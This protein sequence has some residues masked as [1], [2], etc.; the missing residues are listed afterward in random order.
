MNKRLYFPLHLHTTFSIGDGVPTPSEYATALKEK[1]FIGGGIADHGTLSGVWKFQKALKENGLK[2]ILGIEIYVVD[3][4]EKTRDS[5]HLTIFFK[6]KKGWESYLK[7]HKKAFF[8]GF[9]YKPR[10]LLDD[11]LNQPDLDI[12]V[13]SGCVYNLFLE[14][15]QYIEKFIEKFG[16]DFY[17]ELA[18][19]PSDMRRD[20]NEY[21]LILKQKYSLKFCFT[22]DAHYINQEDAFLREIISCINRNEKFDSSV[23]LNKHLCLLD[24]NE[25]A[26]LVMRY[27]KCVSKEIMQAF[28]NTFEVAE[29]CQFE[30][31]QINFKDVLP[32][33]TEKEFFV[34]IQKGL[35]KKGIDFRQKEIAERLDK[36]IKVLLAK[37]FYSNLLLVKD[38]IDF[39]KSKNILVGPGRGSVGGSFI[40]YL[41]DIVA[42]N[43]ID[44]ALPFERFISIDR[45]EP[46]DID[47]DFDD[48]GRQEVI[49]YIKSKYGAIQI[50]SF[51]YWREKQAFRDVCRIMNYNANSVWELPEY[52]R[53]IVDKL[54]GR[55]RHKSRHAAGFILNKEALF[56]IPIE[57]VGDCE[58]LAFEATDLQE[59]GLCKFDVLG[60]K[61]LS[62]IKRVLEITNQPIENF[63][64]SLKKYFDNK[65]IFDKIYNQ[66]KLVGVFMFDT[67]L[68]RQV[69]SDYKVKNFNDLV[70]LNAFIRPGPLKEFYEDIIFYNK[71]GKIRRKYID[72]IDEIVKETYG[73]FLFQEQIM[74]L[75]KSLGYSEVEIN[76]VRKFI[77]KKDFNSLANYK[78]DF[79][80]RLKARNYDKAEE[81]WE[82]V[83][84]FGEYAFNKAHSVAYALISFATAYL[85]Y[86]YPLVFYKAFLEK[87]LGENDIAE[88]INEMISD[89]I[90]VYLPSVSKPVLIAEYNS[91]NEFYLGVMT[92]KGIGEAQAKK[93]CKFNNFYSIDDFVRK[94]KP[95]SDVFKAL[96][97]AG[98]FDDFKISR[99]FL[100]ENAQEILRG[101]AMFLSVK[102]VT[103][104][105]ENEKLK[106]QISVLPFLK[107]FYKKDDEEEDFLKR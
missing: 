61:T 89:N 9:Y 66:K 50:A 2:P 39:A 80:N 60:L 23:E 17:L 65:E 63:F 55:I 69:L 38:F 99:R 3:K 62:V 64:V 101:S 43:P 35:E 57:K 49:D 53:K 21:L 67:Q 96:V 15:P 78:D 58:T 85:K 20:L 41:F 4:Y 12:V 11:F 24:E 54:V 37:D 71:T 86:N 97:C 40:A 83:L 51:C 1:G 31:E 95:Q 52:L 28:E 18:V 81:L 87:N 82:I 13:L 92:I 76:K 84:N 90:N 93:I 48:E 70:S 5:W 27:H 14:R 25:I 77:A 102:D 105:D 42:L 98:F 34:E 22:L 33:K 94:V 75:F 7:L 100:F 79:I 74:Q 32:L 6:S 68:A 106:R 26:N 103:D 73:L 104:W 72:F 44:Y 88:A 91:K 107:I 45:T 59:I 30:I 56:F 46:P 47:I 36:E 29:K 8:E 16:D 19:E 10:I